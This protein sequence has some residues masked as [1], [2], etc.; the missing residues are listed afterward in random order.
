MIAGTLSEMGLAARIRTNLAGLSGAGSEELRELLARTRPRLLASVPG[1]SSA[2]MVSQR[3][4]SSFERSVDALRCLVELGYGDD[5]ALD[6][7]YNPPL[8]EMPASQSAL[9]T[10]FRTAFEPLGI[11]FARVLAIGNVINTQDKYP[12]TVVASALWNMEPTIDLARDPDAG[13]ARRHVRPAPHRSTA[14]APGPA[15]G[16]PL[17]PA[18]NPGRPR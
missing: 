2:R 15:G 8:G 13:R 14:A 1:S 4:P 7:A 9:E 12:D 10:E 17:P 5:L 18:A 3:D 6:L 11:R 16:A